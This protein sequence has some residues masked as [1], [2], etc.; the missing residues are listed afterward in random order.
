M[1]YN[2]V[3]TGYIELGMIVATHLLLRSSYVVRQK[4]NDTQVLSYRY[5]T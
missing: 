3:C 1:N 4:S 2:Y 5:N